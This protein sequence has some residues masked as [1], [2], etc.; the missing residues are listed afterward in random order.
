M[1]DHRMRLVAAE[2]ADD[3]QQNGARLRAAGLKFYFAFAGIGLDIVEPF[4]KIDVPRQAPVFAV[5]D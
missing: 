3:A 2:L 5:G 1:V 4:K